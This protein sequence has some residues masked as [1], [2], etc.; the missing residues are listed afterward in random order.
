MRRPVM[1][2]RGGADHNAWL[3]TTSFLPSDLPNLVA[4][5]RLG[6]GLTNDGGG[7]IS[8]WADQSG[9]GNDLTA[10]TTRRPTLQ[11]DNS[12]LFNGTSNDMQVAFTLNYPMSVFLRVKPV[13]W[14][15]N[16]YITDSGPSVGSGMGI[17]QS[18]S[19][20][21]LYLHS[22]TLTMANSNATLGSWHGL[23]AVFNAA[24]SKFKIDST[25]QVTGN[26]GNKNPA[27]LTLGSFAGHALNSNIYVKELCLYSD[28]KSDADIQSII[29]YLN[30]L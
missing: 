14:S 10:T 22:G 21:D 2:V 9:N 4:W 30:T 19:T 13:T 27:G 3:Y 26:P 12:L 18:G 24:S 16:L 17:V 6:I 5:Y 28:A 25:T 23:G 1:G 8:K 29:D 20:P 7:L 15:D 11:G